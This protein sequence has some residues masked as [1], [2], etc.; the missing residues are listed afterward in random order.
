MNSEIEQLEESISTARFAF[1]CSKLTVEVTINEQVDINIMVQR[2]KIENSQL[3]EQ[4]AGMS[5]DSRLSQ[6]ISISSQ[7]SELC[8]KQVAMFL[9]P[10][11]QPQLIVS[12]IQISTKAQTFRCLQLFREAMRIKEERYLE[13]IRHLQEREA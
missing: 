5:Q 12:A 6:S 13:E 8:K 11:A 10:A 1:R 7:D 3:K 9:S 2:L 4:L